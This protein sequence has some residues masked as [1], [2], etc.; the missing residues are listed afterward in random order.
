[1]TN[2]RSTTRAYTFIFALLVLFM[3]AS[4]VAAGAFPS[5][6][7][8]KADPR[9]AQLAARERQL[10]RN[11]YLTRQI[12]RKRWANYNRA[13]ARRRRQISSRQREIK[14]LQRQ[15]EIAA[16]YIPS[17]TNGYA[18]QAPVVRTVTLSPSSRPVTSTHS[19]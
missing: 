11:A 13:L 9:I 18:A 2:S 7:Q 10:Q 17:R 19:S 6:P 14:R 1:M 15:W 4:V 16:T 5:R 8:P 12:V 3:S